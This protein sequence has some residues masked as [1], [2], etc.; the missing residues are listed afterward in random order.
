[1]RIFLFVLPAALLA[2]V[3]AAAQPSPICRTG[4]PAPDCGTFAVATL[5]YYPGSR[6]T[7][8]AEIPWKLVEWELGW[9]VNR[10]PAQAV[11]ASLA[12]G[13]GETGFHLAVK[14]RYRR[15][16]GRDWALDA[17]AGL[18]VAQHPPQTYP[19]ETLAGVTA[20]AALGL[21]DWVA[22]TGQ[23]RVLWG[24]SD[25][26]TVTGAELGVRL[27]TLPGAIATVLGGAYLISGAARGT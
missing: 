25:G 16:L 15:W 24:A 22:V 20:G 21:T 12:L 6:A 27:G 2:A 3:P 13:T 7:A 8:E 5:N 1:M 17:D 9:M 10:G 11:G 4:R 18:L 19:H 23:G 26:E 14:G